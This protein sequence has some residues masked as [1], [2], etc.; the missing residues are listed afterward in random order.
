MRL[1]ERDASA[2]IRR[3]QTSALAPVLPRYKMRLMDVASNV[4]RSSVWW[5]KRGFGIS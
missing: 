4:L 5:V 1:R 3:H 2:C